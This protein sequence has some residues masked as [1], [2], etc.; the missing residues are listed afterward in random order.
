M[1]ILK[2][3][4]ENIKEMGKPFQPIPLATENRAPRV[5]VQARGGRG[6]VQQG[7][8]AGSPECTGVLPEGNPAEL[9]GRK[10]IRDVPVM[11]VPIISNDHEKEKK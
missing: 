5:P 1:K 6:S 8:Y 3:L 7:S 4:Q 9:P 11:T 2:Y 10:A